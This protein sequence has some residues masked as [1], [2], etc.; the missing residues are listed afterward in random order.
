MPDPSPNRWLWSHRY[1][2]LIPGLWLLL[3]ALGAYF[4]GG[5]HITMAVTW[6]PAIVLAVPLKIP[7]GNSPGDLALLLLLGLVPVIVLGL[8]LDLLKLPIRKF[9]VCC[10]IGQCGGFVLR[11]F[12]FTADAAHNSLEAAW[13]RMDV[14][15]W[16]RLVALVLLL[17]ALGFFIGVLL[18]LGAA[19]LTK[20]RV[21][22][23]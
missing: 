23:N 9:A 17:A 4:K 7:V 20:L 5:E 8:F 18:S 10:L 1:L 2:W 21:Q 19:L 13:G 11:A 6:L 15:H 3:A 12:T 14:G 16:D 22:V